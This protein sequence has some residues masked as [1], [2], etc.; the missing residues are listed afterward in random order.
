ML[1]LVMYDGCKDKDGR[2][3]A[4]RR[5][6]GLVLAETEAIRKLPDVM[7]RVQHGMGHG[8]S[9]CSRSEVSGCSE[10]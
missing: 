7:A 6:Q 4:V 9:S 8:Q 3:Q 2:R 5:G 10:A 1:C